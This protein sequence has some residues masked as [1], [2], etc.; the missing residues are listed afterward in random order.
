[1][2]RPGM[3]SA[4]DVF[5]R[6]LA[7]AL[8]AGRV[9][10]VL[11]ALDRAPS[12]S[13][14]LNPYKKRTDFPGSRPVPWSEYGMMLPGRPVFTLDPFFHGGCYY[15]QD[16]SSMFVGYMLRQV[17]KSMSL[18][19]P[20]RVLD[21]CASPGG[22][23]TDACAS[24]RA[25]CGDDFIL[26]SNEAIRSRVAALAV[27]AAMWGDPAVTV[28]NADPAGFGSGLEGFFDV[29]LADVPCSGEG[30]FRKDAEAVSQWSAENVVHCAARQRRILSDVWPSLAGG[31]VLIY[32]TCTFNVYENDRNVAWAAGN[33]GAEVL[34]PVG[35]EVPAGVIPTEYGFSLVPG[36]VEGE[37]QYCAVLRKTSP[38]DRKVAGRT[39]P[40]KKDSRCLY[41]EN[42]FDIPVRPV[43]RGD[44]VKAVP[45]NI[46]DDV[47]CVGERVRVISSGCAAGSYKGRDFVP[48]ADLALDI[49][50]NKD[51]FPRAEVDRR[52]AL[53]FLHRD[54]IVLGNME[55]GYVLICH[56][57]VPLGF[58]K[59][60]G[61][62][63]N[64][65]YP[66]E[67]RIRMDID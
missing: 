16:S 3:V 17:L 37:G 58:V 57:G 35:A 45:E 26:V 40:G 29:I 56:E 39:R 8:G 42:L 63:C 1:M 28:T 43:V 52:T 47:A 13:V 54:A 49:C 30:M 18:P 33:L 31:G 9:P 59:N 2:T 46:A 44:L 15:V 11:E 36:Y 20:L 12:V 50:L 67:R 32:S 27:N 5:V 24:L 51:A 64:S 53:A 23:T 25:V 55:K 4:N 66:M 14:R 19:A 34:Y 7:E 22:K 62:R 60:L 21:L 6:Y 41:V 65:L 10:A 48:D 61:N 38:Q